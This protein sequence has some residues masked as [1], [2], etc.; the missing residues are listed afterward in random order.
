MKNATL[1]EI[2]KNH[3]EVSLFY[4]QVAEKRN[5]WFKKNKY[6]YDSIIDYYNYFTHPDDSILEWVAQQAILSEI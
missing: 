6:F 2:E 4:D 5:F 3:L 1:T